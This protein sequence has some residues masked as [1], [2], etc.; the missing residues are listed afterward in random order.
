M[1]QLVVP[2]LSFIIEKRHEQ[3]MVTVPIL[4]LSSIE[5]NVF[6]KRRGKSSSKNDN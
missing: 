5:N 4:R 2:K 1:L 6:Y 3:N